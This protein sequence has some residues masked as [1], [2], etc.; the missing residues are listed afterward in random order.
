[1]YVEC[2]HCNIKY[3]NLTKNVFFSFFSFRK[4]RS[5]SESSELTAK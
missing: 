3:F 2:R 4:K 1:M 5:V